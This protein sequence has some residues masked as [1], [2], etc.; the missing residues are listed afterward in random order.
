ME[1]T[2]AI[3]PTAG[4]KGRARGTAIKRT[5]TLVLLALGLSAALATPALAQK[6]LQLTLT[7]DGI[8]YDVTKV[9]NGTWST[10]HDNN[11]ALVFHPT[12]FGEVTRTFYPA[13]GSAPHTET[14]APHASPA[15]VQ[16][17]NPQIDCTF[18]GEFTDAS[19][20]YVDDGSVTVWTS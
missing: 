9:G 12:A 13:D 15:N 16:N 10:A 7:C 8:S 6:G 19:G 14:D 1:T 5:I 17:G 11:S 18:H 20:T 4:G 3:D 2:K